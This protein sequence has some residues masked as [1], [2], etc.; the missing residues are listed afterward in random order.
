MR[1]IPLSLIVLSLMYCCK[2]SHNQ[3][4]RRIE[5]G[6]EIIVNHLEP[7]DL[8]KKR[9]SYNL[10]EDL[11]MDLEALAYADLGVVKPEEAHADS[12]GNIF[13]YDRRRASG[14]FIYKFDKTGR[15][16]SYL[17]RCGQGPGEISSFMAMGIDSR[18]RLWV[19]D[20]GTKKIVFYRSSGEFIGETRYP[21][22]WTNVTP[23]ENEGYVATGSG[24][25]KSEVA[26]GYHLRLYDAAF[27]EIG[28][29]DTYDNSRMIAGGR[30]TGTIPLLTWKTSKD[31][32]YVGNEQRKYEI[33]VYGLDGKLIR[34]IQK[35]LNPVRYPEEFI[36]DTDIMARRRPELYSPTYMPPYNSFMVDDSGYLFVMTYERGRAPDEYLYDI[37]DEKGVFVGKV[38]LGLSGLLGRALNRLNSVIRQHRYYRLRLKQSDYYEIVVYRLERKR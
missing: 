22:R 34:K 27:R 31:K 18:D 3:I 30:T 32:I 4:E 35:D 28:L 38:G 16:V 10:Q 17:G 14:Y 5:D 20:F 7:A 24:L 37:F 6:I 36:K 19:D 33:L 8:K 13:I 15:F 11:R 26:T 2:P 12:Q 9:I 29:L 23:L 25:E 1:S 21:P